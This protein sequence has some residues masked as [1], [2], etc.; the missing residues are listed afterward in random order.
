METKTVWF[1]LL[2]L[3][4]LLHHPPVFLLP[5]TRTCEPDEHLCD[6]GKCIPSFWVCDG[7]ADCLDGS[8]EPPSCDEVTCRPD[9]FTCPL[10]WYS[11]PRC[12]P[13]SYVCDGERDCSN[14]ADELQ[15]CTTRQCHANDQFTC[16]NGM[17]IP[18]AFVCDGDNDCWDNSDE[19]DSLCRTPVP[20]CAPGQFQCSSGECIDLHKVCNGQN[21]C[22][23]MSDERRCGKTYGFPVPVLMPPYGCWV[24][25][26]ILSLTSG[27]AISAI[28][29]E[30]SSELT[31]AMHHALGMSLLYAIWYG[32]QKQTLRFLLRWIDLIVLV[33]HL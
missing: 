23:D 33:T 30:P 28:D 26:I 29:V 7:F 21:D 20:T 1:A 25:L 31:L 11:G 18:S 8:D 27:A 22:N 24:F 3:L 4:L 16:Q 5:D 15:N 2:L 9:E 13:K 17:C 32:I 19:L 14:A 10:P 12:I 6:S